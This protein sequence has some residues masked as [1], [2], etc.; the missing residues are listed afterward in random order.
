[1]I[2]PGLLLCLFLAVLPQA[3]HGT[4]PRDIRLSLV[5]ITNSALMPDYRAPWNPGT[6]SQGRG[7]GFIIN[8]NRIMTNAHVV[9]N[10]RFLAVER[11]GDPKIY[12][13]H[14]AFIGHDCDLAVLT[15]DDPA[16]FKNM[17]PL[18]F[19]KIPELESSVTV[20]GY[21]IGGDRMSV[22]R[23]VVSR[24]DFQVYSHS[25]I[26][27]HLIVQIDAAIN[28]GNSGGPVLQDGRVVGVAFQGFS[29]D[30]AQN[31][32]YII[33]VPVIS[34]FLKDIS[35]GSYDHYVELAVNYFNLINPGERKALGLKD[36]DRGVLVSSV[37]KGGA[38]DG[39]L[40]PGDVL[41]TVNEHPVGSDGFVNLDG[42]RVQMSEIVERKFKNDVV[43]FTVL[44]GGRETDVSVTLKPFWPYTMA[45]FQYD[46]RP[47][48]IVFGGL[49]FQPL[50][51]NLM[52]ALNI[53]NLRL[54]YLF[55]RFVSD[56]I[57]LERSDIVVL[58]D[59][60]SDTINSYLGPARLSVVSKVNG[61]SIRSME[62]LAAALAKPS[63]NYVIALEGDSRPIVL[64]SAAV[65]SARERIKKS[66]NITEEQYLGNT[67][68]P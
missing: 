39:L 19:D 61:A 13:A 37:E 32:G 11:E 10:S 38:A 30:T 9:S 15:V 50:T 21:P 49:V 55:E 40:L 65:N 64:E 48:F 62:D 57:Y 6:L 59:V 67:V 5:R 47:R 4:E 56:S 46:T 63:S 18:S 29:G 17:L 45:G 23:G 31:V 54:R 33:P 14:V 3:G 44:R 41:L 27:S 24:V 52:Q 68:N 34:R 26:D 36:D 12:P 22:T 28:P 58:S 2:R 66:Y 35:D 16:F 20:Y 1:M 25:S 8:D 42:N 7:T 60:L 43:K 53:N 51:R